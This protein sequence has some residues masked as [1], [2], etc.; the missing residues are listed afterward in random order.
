MTDITIHATDGSGSFMAY[1]AAPRGDHVKGPVGVVVL[2]QEI[3]GVNTSLRETADQVAGLG[4][5]VIAPDLFWR[6][7]PGVNISD[8]TQ[9]EWDKAFTLFNG[10][11]QA[12]G[13]E[14]L[15]ATLAVA[16]MFPGSTGKVATM[17]Y[18]L[19]GRL[20]F[21]MATRSDA[22]LNISYYGVGLEGLLDEVAQI[23][24]PLVL[25]MAALDKF[26]PAEA[27]AAILAG[28]A[29][30]AWVSP[31]V[32]PGAEHAFARVNGIHWDT[33]S[34]WIANGRSA[35]ALAEALG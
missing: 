34:A 16:R 10:F 20:A 3:F 26:V 5:H 32:Y 19:G 2:I 23:S 7:E 24:K 35:A 30:N 12:K 8:Q 18:C 33:R 1:H 29:G 22:D 14:D 15:Q 21:M 28:V 4:Y 25:H 27:R 6:Q 13:I 31:H 11:D 9:A 17:G